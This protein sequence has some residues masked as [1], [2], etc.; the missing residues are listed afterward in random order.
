[1]QLYGEYCMHKKEYKHKII[2]ELKYLK[3]EEKGN[4]EIL[5]EHPQRAR[6]Q[7][8][9][10]DVARQNDRFA[11]FFRFFCPQCRKSNKFK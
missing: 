2:V 6:G 7:T 11:L 8:R 5:L 9:A 1:M 3:F 10:N 4:S